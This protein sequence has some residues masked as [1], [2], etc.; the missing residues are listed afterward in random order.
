MKKFRYFKVFPH[1]QNGIICI[2]NSFLLDTSNNILYNFINVDYVK[3]FVSFDS[4]TGVQHGL[5]YKSNN[6]NSWVGQI[7]QSMIIK[8]T[9]IYISYYWIFRGI[10]VYDTSQQTFTEFYE[11]SLS[12]FAF[13]SIFIYNS[14]L[15]ITGYIFDYKLNI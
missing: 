3:L 8:G 4:E 1:K 15:F 6:T 13:G 9:K 5:K 14:R 10:L 11:S 12:S 2:Y 7:S